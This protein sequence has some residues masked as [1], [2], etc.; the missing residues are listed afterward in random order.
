MSLNMIDAELTQENEDLA[1]Q[2]VRDGRSLLPFLVGLPAK[3]IRRMPK[4]GDSYVEFVNR[5]RYH[6][7]MF[8]KYF[9]ADITLEIFNRDYDLNERLQR[10]SKVVK[11]F[12][13]DL[14]D[15]ILLLKSEF[16]KASRLYYSNAKTAGKAGDKDAE[17]IAKDLSE[18]YMKR[19]AGS[20]TPA[21]TTDTTA[22][23][24]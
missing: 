12:D 21:E 6:A 3:E 8:P 1:I 2:H 5:M 11:S 10:V 7:Q 16:Y 15:T 18:H 13:K 4:L 23:S 9:P 14:D 22:D 20:E 19:D 24:A 17:R